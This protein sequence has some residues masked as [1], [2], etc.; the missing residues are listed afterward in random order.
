MKLLN[1]YVTKNIINTILLVVLVLLALEIFIGF[2]GEM[3]DIG[4]G[5][6]GVLPAF[7][8]VLL[9]IPGKLYSFFPMASL[10]GA[11]LGLGLLASNS[12][13][14]VMR[15]AGVSLWRI[16]LMVLQ[17]ALLLTLLV[18]IVGECLAP[19]MTHMAESQKALQK[20]HGR[21]LRTQGGLWL[22]APQAYIHIR[23][24]L[25]DG[26]L[27]GI[28][29]YQFDEQHRLITASYSEL[30]THQQDQWVLH[31]VK[32]SRVGK[33]SVSAQHYKT[34]PW[35]ISFSPEMLAIAA[36]QPAE[37]SLLQLHY[38]IA[39]AKQNGLQSISYQLAFWQ[40]LIQPIGTCIMML[41][42]IPFIFGPLRS[43][44]M[45]LRML[46]GITLGFV[47]YILNQFFGPL[48]IVYQ[49]PPLFAAIIPT[50]LFAGVGYGFMRKVN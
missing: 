17:T 19:L 12:E 35:K 41:L 34:L 8:Y 3:G 37:M 18:S 15:A 20:S 36:I 26:H 10:L 21:A 4:K 5:E 32:Q 6:Y 22:R 16:T 46:L 31:D 44:S 28:S 48:S 47:F 38:Y 33:K 1:R 14:I 29:S 27:S 49:L 23:S 2:I 42:A 30:A 39:A 45:G 43:S 40:R 13:L 50:L 25:P 24:I 9:S 11:L 7:I